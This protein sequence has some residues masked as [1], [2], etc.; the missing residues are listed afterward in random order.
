M[1]ADN[2][3]M[4]E[5]HEIEEEDAENSLG[6]LIA[7]YA[8]GD[9]SASPV[10][11]VVRTETAATTAAA[12]DTSF[13]RRHTFPSSS[14]TKRIVIIT[15]KNDNEGPMVGHAVVHAISQAK[16]MGLQSSRANLLQGTIDHPDWEQSRWMDEECI[17]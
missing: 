6:D 1:A 14:D 12:D 16:G 9:D 4:E 11:G 15:K 5:K 13:F 7:E 10:A 8:T 3:I 2:T 17:F